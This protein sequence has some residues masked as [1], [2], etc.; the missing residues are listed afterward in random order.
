MNLVSQVYQNRL[1]FT[2][3]SSYE[4]AFEVTATTFVVVDRET[5]GRSTQDAAGA[6]HEKEVGRPIDEITYW[7][8]LH[9]HS[10]ANYIPF[11]SLIDGSLIFANDR[12][13]IDWFLFVSHFTLL[14]LC[15]R[16]IRN[17]SNAECRL[18]EAAYIIA[19]VI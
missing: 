8:P 13:Q 19:N 15:V 5:V 6:L 1:P 2:F 9:T 14:L 12:N 17:S 18:V 16:S 4:R 3:R 10:V 11:A 7:L